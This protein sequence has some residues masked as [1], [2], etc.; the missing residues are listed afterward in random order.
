MLKNSTTRVLFIA[1]LPP[2]TTGQ[3]LACEVLLKALKNSREHEINVVNLSKH[4]LTQGLD[5][6]G[7]V[8]EVASILIRV[9]ILQFRADIIYFTIAESRAGNIKD[10]LIYAACLFNLRR[11]VIHLHGGA[12]LRRL[13]ESRP[14]LRRLNFFFLRRM[15]RVL[16][17]GPRLV[18][19]FVPGLQADRVAVVPNFAS[20]E[21]F[22]DAP[23]IREKFREDD[24]L[25]VLFLSNLLPGKGHI[26]LVAA[27]RSMPPHDRSRIRVNFAGLFEDDEQKLAF[28]DAIKDIPE[29]T[30]HGV[31]HGQAKTKLF[32]NAHVFCLPTYYPFEGQPIS[33]LEA[34]A[35]GCAVVTSDHSGIFDVFEDDVNGFAVAKRSPESISKA[36]VRALN[37]RRTLE[38]IAL[39]NRRI[40]SEKYTT[41]RFTSSLL[42]HLGH[43]ELKLHA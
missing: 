40:A 20:T 18:S 31:V 15:R 11:M 6:L 41:A 37:D 10:I 43:T 21:L 19:I 39:T 42:H 34:Y 27:L 26:E 30:Y 29:I 33:I 5:S 9:F 23:R 25:R 14:L 35:S 12:G 32:A 3:S 16:V 1:P 36:L 22:L 2:P 17:L 38:R 13:F 4:G 8:I 28:L 7:R 24:S